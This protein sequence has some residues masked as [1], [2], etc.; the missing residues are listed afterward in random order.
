MNQSSLTS[1]LQI[2]DSLDRGRLSP[3]EDDEYIRENSRAYT[4]GFYAIQ[5]N[6]ELLYAC[7]NS[8]EWYFT[9]DHE[10]LDYKFPKVTAATIVPATSFEDAQ[11][12]ANLLRKTILY[13]DFVV[14]V[15]R[16]RLDGR[17][18]QHL[19]KLAVLHDLNLPGGEEDPTRRDP[20]HWMKALDAV[21]TPNR[22]YQDLVAAGRCVF[23][24]SR[25]DVYQPPAGSNRYLPPVVCGKQ[26]PYIPLNRR[27]ILSDA[28]ELFIY[29]NLILPY[30][31]E[32]DLLALSKIQ[33]EETDSFVRFTYYLKRRLSQLADLQNED[34]VEDVIEEIDYEVAA[35][36]LEAQKLSKSRLL[37][38]AEIASFSISLGAFASSFNPI[39]GG[40]SGLLGSV[41][42]L[43]LLRER[44]ARRKDVIELKKSDFYIPYLLS[45]E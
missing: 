17:A 1:C 39:L 27:S 19:E 23:L 4:L 15:L 30:F 22:H 32:V 18:L 35:L 9:Q 3:R 36:R 29:K 8:A 43:G 24:P 40:I 20:D 25:L 42:V 10:K 45:S 16:Q 41:T 21:L 13:S 34:Q 12:Y 2:L 14:I 28:F 11:K 26:Q 5:Q 7:A 31:P 33:N 38:G 6:C 37:R 44:A